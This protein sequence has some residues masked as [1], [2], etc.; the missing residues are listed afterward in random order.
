[1]NLKFKGNSAIISGGSGG[2]GLA[3]VG[4]LIEAKIRILIIDIKEPPKKI[5]NNK[6][7]SFAKIDLT[8]FIEIKKAVKKFTNSTKR[9]DYLINAAGILMFNEDIGVEKINIKV[10][11]KVFDIN[12]TSMVYL[13]KCAI[14]FM[15]KNKYGSIVNISSVDALSGDDKPQDAYGASKAAMIRLSK[16]IAI[17]FAKNQIRSNT[18]LPGPVET[19]MQ[20]RWKK[21]PK[22]KKN[23]I[24]FIPLQRIGRPE[25]IA[26]VVIFLLSDNSDYITGSEIT[27]DGG[28]TAKP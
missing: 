3:I 24:K 1:M 21:D 4:K 7:I 15:K 26:N 8:E 20:D 18:I 22:S 19:P 6:L 28:L 10:W 16:S 25:D 9:V 5:L 17:Q 2:M 11:N 23:L 12:L 14:P 13:L 27:V